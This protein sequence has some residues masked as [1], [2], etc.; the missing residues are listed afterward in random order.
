MKLP[1]IKI[2]TADLL[3]AA[4]KLTDQQLGRAL[5]GVCEQAFENNTAYLPA[6]PREQV[7]FDMLM[8][9][10]NESFELYSNKKAA[11]RKG[12]K[13]TQHKYRKIDGSK[14]TVSALNYLPKQTETDTETET[15]TETKTKT[16][17]EN[18]SLTAQPAAQGERA[19]SLSQTG[20][21]L[22]LV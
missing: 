18:I 1:Y 3:A 11:G 4:R 21:S 19:F 5:V 15:K 16:E 22:N 2:Y 17:T 20:E 14:G 12:G 13:R 9:W 10:K 6:S 8:Q 7:F